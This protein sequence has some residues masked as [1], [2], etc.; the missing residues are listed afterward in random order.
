MFQ[1]VSQQPLNLL[2]LPPTAHARTS[3]NSREGAL[4]ST[5]VPY[6]F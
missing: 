4:P 5:L 2:V 3:Q 6:R 1:Q